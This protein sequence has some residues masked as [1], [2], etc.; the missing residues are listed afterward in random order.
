MPR[1]HI[2]AREIRGVLVVALVAVLIVWL[3]G[4]LND[5]RAEAKAQRESLQTTTSVATTTSS[6]TT[7]I[8]DI[9]ERLCNISETFR[10]DLASLPAR[11]LT[12]SG[13]Q[14]ATDLPIDI[15]F[16]PVEGETPTVE[17]PPRIIDPERIDP[18]AS[19]LLGDPQ[20]IALG[21]YSAASALRLG[22]IDADFD[23]SSDYLADLI[24]VADRYAWDVAVIAQSNVADRWTALTTQ[25]PV[26]VE[27]SLDYIE[28]T[29]GIAIGAGFVYREPAPELP[30]LEQVFVPTEIDP[31]VD[32][33]ARNRSPD[34]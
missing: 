31:S 16:A 7:T 34:E 27:N 28:E 9:E 19:G 21:F 30:V 5:D 15:G 17:A 8:V 18:V 20:R 12:P 26:G 33:A 22:L 10:A 14:L 24:D 4:K 29:C 6:T 3:F 1:S 13:S 32:P 25:P 2:A 23:A 11:L